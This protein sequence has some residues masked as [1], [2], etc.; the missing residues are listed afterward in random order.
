[1][2]N[3]LKNAQLGTAIVV[4]ASVMMSAGC[5]VPRVAAAVRGTSYF[6]ANPTER[7]SVLLACREKGISPF[8]D[9]ADA[10]E[11]NAAAT[12]L[13]AARA[14]LDAEIAK[15]S[16]ELSRTRGQAAWDALDKKSSV[17]PAGRQ[18]RQTQLEAE[19]SQLRAKRAE[20]Q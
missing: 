11:C 4:V 1:M 20:L 8:A 7:R 18:R 17:D 14:A 9:T 15:K 16:F 6:D 12:S 19:V 5:D 10:R 13:N 3:S 2:L